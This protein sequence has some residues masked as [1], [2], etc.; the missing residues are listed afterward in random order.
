MNLV[1]R[2]AAVGLSSVLVL[3]LPACRHIRS[4]PF[5][6]TW[7]L[8]AA[9]TTG[10][11]DAWRGSI[12]TIEDV[13]GGKYKLASESTAAGTVR[14]EV[15]FAFDGKDYPG[16]SGT[17]ATLQAYERVDANTYKVTVKRAG[18]PGHLTS[19]SVVS[20]DGKTMTMTY[21]G[22]GPFATLSTV[23]VYDRK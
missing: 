2:L 5:V 21:M 19:T 22:V 9:Q 10:A 12:F 16:P 11:G 18:Q 13:G 20:A 4:D 1:M 14:S 6:G 3:S 17:P 7:V 15:T 23:A 8:N